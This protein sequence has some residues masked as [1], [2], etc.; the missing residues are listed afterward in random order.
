MY[1]EQHY[2]KTIIDFIEGRMQPEAF[3][4]WLS[5]NPEVHDWLQTLIPEEKTTKQVIT[6]KLGYY[7]D[8]LPQDTANAIYELHAAFCNTTDTSIENLAITAKKLFELIA[9]IDES[10]IKSNHAIHLISTEGIQVFDAYENYKANYIQHWLDQTKNIM[11]NEFSDVIAVPYNVK[12]EL[13]KLTRKNKL[14][15]RLNVQGWLYNLM[16]EIYPNEQLEKDN[17]LSEKYRFMLDVC[18]DYIG[19]CDIDDAEIIDKLI[20]SVPADLPK[21]KRTKEIKARI[22]DAFHVKGIVYPRWVQEPEWPL[23]KSGKPMRFVD[24]KR[25]KGKEYKD[26]LYTLYTFEDVDTG[27]RVVVEQFT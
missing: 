11:D 27:E 9:D 1:N 10:I 12:D 18:P 15:N 4:A 7:L 26:M 13:S 3:E 2:K 24:Q 8:K 19:G 5:E 6:V 21:A 16:K 17:T 20:D 23:S 22:K 25:K 14:A